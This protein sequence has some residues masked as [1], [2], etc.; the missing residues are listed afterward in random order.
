MA[1]V[2]VLE[3][4]RQYEV[5]LVWR[6]FYVAAVFRQVNH[7]VS[8]MRSR[9]V[10]SKLAYYKADMQRW[11]ER[12]GIRIGRPPVYGGGSAPL[13]SAPALR[14]AFIAIDSGRI[15]EYAG[16]VFR[17]YW[18]DLRDIS[19]TDVLLELA[20]EAGIDTRD[21]EAAMQTESPRERLRE[22]TDE[23]VRR[24]GFGTPTLFLNGDQ[25]FFGNDR[26]P[27]VEMALKGELK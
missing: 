19:N 3:I 1:F 5:D 15:R 13:N 2:Q 26:L 16:T 14:G 8:E 24:G 4:E 21:F 22:T 25:M 7:H 27:F 17:A 10:D 9:P 12:L 18:E 11:A 20:C 23:F 6:P